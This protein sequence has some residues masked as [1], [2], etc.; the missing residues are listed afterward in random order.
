MRPL[1]VISILLPALLF[2]LIAFIAL[3]ENRLDWTV[4]NAMRDFAEGHAALRHVMIGF[5]H[6]G[7]VPA[8]C[9][10]AAGGAAWLAWRGRYGL[11][12]AWV[13]VPL[14][15]GL[16]DLGLKTVIARD[17]P[18]LELR[19]AAVTETNESFPSG[20]AMGSTIGY[21]MVGYA[22]FVSPWPRSRKALAIAALT[23]LI[24]CIGLS[25]IFLRAHWL[26]DVLA[27]YAI[28][29]AWLMLCV[30]CARE[31]AERACRMRVGRM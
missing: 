26:T 1:A 2:V 20:H 29:V 5:T 23:L 21:G 9:L 11:A 16:L 30:R 7:G 28:G 4:A 10:L 31:T 6:A 19:D 14:G 15:G 25:R 12:V 17:R 27:G 13:A 18:P 8:M 22:V 24:G 3:P